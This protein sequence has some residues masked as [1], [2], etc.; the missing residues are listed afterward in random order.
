M[1]R[2]PRHEEALKR[3]STLVDR[4]DLPG[5]RAREELTR[6]LRA[7]DPEVAAENLKRITAEHLPL[8]RQIA[9]EALDAEGDAVVRRH[10]IALLGRFAGPDEVNLLA[11]LARFDRDPAVRG[12]ALLS[13]GRSGVQLAAPLLG[14]A[15]ASSDAVEAA[16]AAKAV[17]A[18][19]EK[20]GAARLRASVGTLTKRGL[21]LLD[22]VLAQPQGRARRRK[23]PAAAQTRRDSKD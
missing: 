8:L 3:P 22:Q 11:D 10:A 5:I 23:R 18:L 19:A 1:A 7:H 9:Q 13:L 14:N 6:L 16:A 17:K 21:R 15:L 12:E 2:A 20:L 4:W